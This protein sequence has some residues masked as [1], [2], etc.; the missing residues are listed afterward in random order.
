MTAAL[1]V[2][3]LLVV[4]ALLPVGIGLLL[5]PSAARGVRRLADAERTRTG[6]P[7]WG[8]GPRR[9]RAAVADPLWRRDVRWLP[10]HAVKPVS[11]VLPRCT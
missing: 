1:L 6:S 3:W 10:P 8:P 5:V 7:T 2:L 11:A 9:L 4:L